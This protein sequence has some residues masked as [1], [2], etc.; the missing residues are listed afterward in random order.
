MATIFQKTPADVHDTV[1]QAIKS[2]QILL[3]INDAQIITQRI[4]H[5]SHAYVIYNQWRD[6]NLP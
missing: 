1:N 2:T 4:V 5:I 3:S 6:K